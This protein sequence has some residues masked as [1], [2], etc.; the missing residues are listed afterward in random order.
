MLVSLRAQSRVLQRGALGS[1]SADHHDFVLPWGGFNFDPYAFV[2]F[3]V[4]SCRSARQ[5]GAVLGVSLSE[6][7]L[8]VGGVGSPTQ[9]FLVTVEAVEA[10]WLYPLAEPKRPSRRHPL[11][12]K[13]AGRILAPQRVTNNKG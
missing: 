11:Q 12:T 7:H 10:Q 2:E 4:P 8:C 13:A 3:P 1:A 6:D 9:I 5:P